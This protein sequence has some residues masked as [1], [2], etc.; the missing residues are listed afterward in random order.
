LS[1]RTAITVSISSSTPMISAGYPLLPGPRAKLAGPT[2]EEWLRHP[3][4]QRQ[5]GVATAYPVP[6]SVPAAQLGVSMIVKGFTPE[7][8]VKVFAIMKA[9]RFP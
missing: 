5:R 6:A 3:A 7:N 2:F 1:V 9:A 4:S 8:G